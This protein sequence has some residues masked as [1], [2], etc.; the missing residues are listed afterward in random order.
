VSTL[1][2]ALARIGD[3]WDRIARAAAGVSHHVRLALGMPRYR[4]T[5]IATA[6]VVLVLYLASIGDL[7][8]STTGRW[9]TAPLAQAAPENV[10]TAR[11]PYLF[12]PVLQ[13]HPG[14]HIAVFLSPVNL[15]LGG[16]VA[17]LAGCN[18]AVARYV[19]HH[20]ACRHRGYRG[21]LGALPSF[22]LGFACCTPTVLL[23]LSAGAGAAVLPLLL[24]LRPFFYPVTLVLL[25]GTL[26]WEVRRL[27]SHASTLASPRSMPSTVTS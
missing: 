4:R 16:I 19:A 17:A 11:A 15:L 5:A 25:T 10:L 14:A 12:E 20:T 7:A 23:A 18:L 2:A 6:A 21:L 9:T 22:L 13:L 3:M 24:P 1:L 27:R 8:F 26:V